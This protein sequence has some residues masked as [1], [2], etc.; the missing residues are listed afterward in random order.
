M[1][2]FREWSPHSSGPFAHVNTSAAAGTEP[3]RDDIVHGRTCGGREK[4]LGGPAAP[5][6][7]V[8]MK[9]QGEKGAAMVTASRDN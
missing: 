7:M 4:K 8:G 3:A 9:R 2:G 6:V 1:I 5:P